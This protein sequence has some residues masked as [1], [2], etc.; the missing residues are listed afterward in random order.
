MWIL[1]LITICTLFFLYLKWNF[2]YWQRKGFPFV[3]PVIPFGVLDSVRKRER[4]F[5][6]A[7]YDVYKASREKVLGIYLFTRPAL[8]IRDAQLARDILTKD[9]TSFHDRG[10][11]VNEDEDPMSGGLFFLKGQKWKS[12]RTK[13]APS[14]TS[15]KLKAMF[16]TVDEVSEKMVNYLN[17]VVPEDGSVEIEMKSIM[18]M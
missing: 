9:F 14:F 15:G 13:L 8:L 3:E 18:S 5:G 7:I 1:L 11:Y 17:S 4:S 12:L 10:V 2:T 16:T 6:M